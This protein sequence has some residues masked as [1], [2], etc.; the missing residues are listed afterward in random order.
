MCIYEYLRSQL[1][2]N[3]CFGSDSCI[4]ALS[5]R[6]EINRLMEIIK[7]RAVEFPNLER[8]KKAHTMAGGAEAEGPSATHQ[9]PKMLFDENQ[10]DKPGL[11]GISTPLPQSVVSVQYYTLL[12]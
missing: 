1:H 3:L 9:I 2:H 7:S 4:C 8:E 10:E 11:W 5:I 6:V 12:I